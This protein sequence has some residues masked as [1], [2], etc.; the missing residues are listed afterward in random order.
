MLFLSDNVSSRWVK[1]IQ[2]F[3][4]SIPFIVVGTKGDKRGNQDDSASKS[5]VTQ[6]E[7][8]SQVKLTKALGYYETS[9]MTG[10]G[11]SDAFEA[12]AIGVLA[13]RKTYRG[14]LIM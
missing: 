2:D 6:T 8:Q 11:L 3:K 10:E 5:F 1:D 14:C 4:K 13:K 12:A 9:A 7:A